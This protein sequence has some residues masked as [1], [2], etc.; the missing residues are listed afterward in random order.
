[1][2][3]PFVVCPEVLSMELFIS[4]DSFLGGMVGCVQKG[5]VCRWGRFYF[6]FSSLAG[7]MAVVSPWA[8]LRS[9]E[10]VTVGCPCFVPDPRG[11]AC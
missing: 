6:S 3:F 9:V 10:V 11:K 5:V 1:M 7:L 4:S 8:P 2:E